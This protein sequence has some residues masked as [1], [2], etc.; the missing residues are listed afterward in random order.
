MNKKAIIAGGLAV[1]AIGGG[2]AAY[3]YKQLGGMHASWARVVK[4]ETGGTPHY[5]PIQYRAKNSRPAINDPKFVSVAEANLA[6]GTK[7]IGVAVG[8]DARFYPLYILSYNQIVND[9]CGGKKIA[10][11]Y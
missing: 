2:A 11:T 9:T 6:G 10:C 3:K 5:E 8:D 4:T 1:V 7:G